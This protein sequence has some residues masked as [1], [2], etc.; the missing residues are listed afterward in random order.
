M[1]L[2]LLIERVEIEQRQ[3]RLDF[4]V[5][6]RKVIV[7]RCNNVSFFVPIDFGNPKTFQ[8]SLPVPSELENVFPELLNALVKLLSLVRV[9]GEPPSLHLLGSVGPRERPASISEHIDAVALL[10][11]DRLKDKLNSNANQEALL[12]VPG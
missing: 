12:G 5:F 10:E 6:R 3:S 11:I 2:Q 9:E 8:N 1:Q 7:G 4:A